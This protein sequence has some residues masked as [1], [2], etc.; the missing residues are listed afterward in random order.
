MT[1]AMQLEL[2]DGVIIVGYFALTLGIGAW[3]TRRAG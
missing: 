2:I 3:F 1:A